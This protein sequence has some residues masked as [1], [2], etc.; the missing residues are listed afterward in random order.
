MTEPESKIN[1]HFMNLVMMLQ[2]S[3]MQSMGKIASPVSGE[4]E[5]NLDHCRVSIDMLEMLAEKTS[6]NLNEDEKKYIDSTLYNLRMNYL[7]EYNKAD[8]E[9]AESDIDKD[10]MSQSE[11]PDK[12]DTSET[13]K[14]ENNQS[15]AEKS[16]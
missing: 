4:I 13:E 1:P 14:P 16:D 2:M 11:N 7:E 5:K 8:E 12:T 15:T 6:G 10:K 9:K 3:A